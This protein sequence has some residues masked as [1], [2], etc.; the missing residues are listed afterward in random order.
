MDEL[1]VGSYE[2]TDDGQTYVGVGRRVESNPIAVPGSKS[3]SQR[4]DSDVTSL[5]AMAAASDAA[6]GGTGSATKESLR[7]VSALTTAGRGQTGMQSD[8]SQSGMYNM[9]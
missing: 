5:E 6:N 1:A 7:A 2:A 8:E 4:S 9:F 3:S